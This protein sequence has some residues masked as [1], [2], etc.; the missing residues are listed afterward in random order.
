MEEQTSLEKLEQMNHK[1]QDMID[2]YNQNAQH[3]LHYAVGYDVSYRNHYYLIP[4]LMK[5][6]DQ[7]MY[8]DKRYKKQH[9]RLM[10]IGHTIIL[11]DMHTVFPQNFW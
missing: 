10:D 8:E 1:L 7:K 3:P 9:M 4:D 6:A 2:D 11:Q 5:I